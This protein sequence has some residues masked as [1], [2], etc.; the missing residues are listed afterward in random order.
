MS[1]D[2]SSAGKLIQTTGPCTAKQQVMTD[3]RQNVAS[4]LRRSQLA[5]GPRG[6]GA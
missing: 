3:Y 1:G 2:R 4:K 5:T 6:E